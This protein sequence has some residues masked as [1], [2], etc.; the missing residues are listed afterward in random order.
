MLSVGIWNTPVALV[1]LGTQ[2]DVFLSYHHA[3][4]SVAERIVGALR[5]KGLTVFFDREEV[6]DFEGI[7]ARLRDGLGRSK[8]VL[9]LYSA[10][11]PSRRACQFELTSA[12]LAAQ[13]LGSP[14]NHVLV[15]NPEPGA[16]HIRP[17]ELRDALFRR[18]PEAE[19]DAALADLATAVAQH[20]S[21]LDGQLDEAAPLALPRWLGMRPSAATRF[22]G[23]Q[24]AMWEIHSALH[25]SEFQPITGVVG[26]GVAQVRG[27]GGIGKTLLAQEYALR[28]CAAFPGGIF[29]LRAGGDPLAAASPDVEGLEAAR[30]SQLRAFAGACDLPIAE[31]STPAEVEAAFAQALARR[32]EPFLWVVDDVPRDLDADALRAW[33]APH[34]LGRTLLTTQS[35]QY[36]ALAASV[37]PSVLNPDEAAT[38]LALHRAPSNQSEEREAARLADE[39]GFHALAVDVAGAAIAG[40]PGAAPFA[41]FRADLRDP[42]DDAL[43]FAAELAD[44]LPTGH[45]PSIA[46]TLLASIRNLGSDGLDLLRIAAALSPAPIPADFFVDVLACS[47]GESEHD[48]RR[49]VSKARTEARYA[50]LAERSED[51]EADVVHALISRTIRFHS[52]PDSSDRLDQL[53]VAAMSVMKDS[54]SVDWGDGRERVARQP[55]VPHARYLA[56]SVTD[57]PGGVEMLAALARYDHAAGSYGSARDLQERVLA[58]QIRVS[59]VEHTSTLD[60]MINL[61]ATLRVQGAFS[62]ARALEEQAVEALKRLRGTGHPRTLDAMN[63]LAATLL[64]LGDFAGARKLQ[65]LVLEGRLQ[66]SSAEDP[67]TLKSLGNLAESLRAQGDLVGARRLQELV[68]EGNRRALGEDHP[69]LLISMSALAMTLWEQRELDSAQ[70]LEEQ[71]LEASSRALGEEHPTTLTSM[72]NLAE[73]LAAQGDHTAARK[74][75]EQVVEAADRVLGKEHPM[76]LMAMSNLGLAMAQQGEVAEGRAM[77]EHVL[78]ARRRVLGEE[79]PDT[80]VSM[81]NL[82]STLVAQGDPAGAL[83]LV[84]LTLEKRRRSLGETHPSTRNS[85]RLEA[86]LAKLLGR[87]A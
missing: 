83:K 26:M 84:R 63:N 43:E 73:T 60:A 2:F 76:T 5:A 8:A 51:G 55:L 79:H 12:F 64:E 65:E 3:D 81:S 21:A 22:V 75:Q 50:S 35:G 1:A 59:G 15:V 52:Q 72:I 62:E 36:G 16:E 49:R 20:V 10:T 9:V 47:D 41:T 86:E 27:L 66:H 44:M 4:G 23:R 34:P 56:R 46:A 71:V 7:T 24:T 70:E 58:S 68:V 77:Q 74:L 6:E 45:S 57:E 87:S 33:L 48:A 28:F 30:I 78:E 85:A 53:R 61:G 13:R 80:L 82:V 38:L 32:N 17:V 42:A 19:D 31:T 67:V 11:Y 14:T 40:T 25:A 37:E 54:L 18:C 39:L 29:W 69:D